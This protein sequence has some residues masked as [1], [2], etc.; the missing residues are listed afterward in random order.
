MQISYSELLAMTL[1][2]S[3]GC[4]LEHP[5]L[6]FLLLS[7]S[8]PTPLAV[9]SHVFTFFQQLLCKYKRRAP[10]NGYKL[11]MLGLL[12]VR[13]RFVIKILHS[14]LSSLAF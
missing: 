3:R 4:T 8:S 6:R 9:L 12:M 5:Y 2:S 7:S 14:F 10:A 1:S 11:E 13:Y